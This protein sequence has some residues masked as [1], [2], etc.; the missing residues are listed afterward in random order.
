[1]VPY[2]RI[3]N[4]SVP[5]VQ[6]HLVSENHQ[7]TSFAVKIAENSVRS[8]AGKSRCRYPKGCARNIIHSCRL[9]RLF[10]A[11]RWADR[12]PR[13]SVAHLRK[14]EHAASSP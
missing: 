6:Q 1:M 13:V 12:T 11:Q 14:L 8:A 2:L 9:H 4:I 7:I 3:D 10:P 5:K